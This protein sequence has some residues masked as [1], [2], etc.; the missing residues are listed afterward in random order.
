MKHFEAIQEK[1]LQMEKRHE[2]REE[3]MQQIIRN[4]KHVATVQLDQESHKWMKV[5]ED[6]NLEIQKFRTEL[7]SILEVLRLL[8]KQGVVIPVSS[9]VT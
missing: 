3:E 8:Q 1:I 7:D 6:K 4:A 2:R 5:V 9:Q